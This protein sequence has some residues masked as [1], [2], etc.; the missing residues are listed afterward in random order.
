MGGPSVSGR[1]CLNLLVSFEFTCV[2]P[3]PIAEFDRTQH[4]RISHRLQATLEG[5]ASDQRGRTESPKMRE[6]LGFDSD[7]AE[8]GPARASETTQGE[9]PCLQGV[10]TASK[11]MWVIP[12]VTNDRQP[13]PLSIRRATVAGGLGTI[14]WDAWTANL[15]VAGLLFFTLRLDTPGK[16]ATVWSI[17]LILEHSFILESPRRPG[18]VFKPEPTESLLYAR[19]HLPSRQN[20]LGSSQADR[21]LPLWQGD[22]TP[23]LAKKRDIKSIGVRKI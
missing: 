1:N 22:E 12:L 9:L 8:L 16:L 10:L 19:G 3:C 11:E 20:F 7:R 23:G 5:E 4:G 6:W 2:V 15:T 21:D 18:V 17:Q 13:L 14:V